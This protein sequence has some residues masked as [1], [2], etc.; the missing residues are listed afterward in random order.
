MTTTHKLAI[1][2][3][4]CAAFVPTF[5]AAASRSREPLRTRFELIIGV[6]FEL[7]EATEGPPLATGEVLFAEDEATYHDLSKLKEKLQ[8]TYGLKAVYTTAVAIKDIVVGATMPMPTEPSELGVELTL[9]DYDDATAT[10][11]VRLSAGGE[12]LANPKIVVKLGGRAI[13]AA[14]DGERAP[15]A[16]I[17]V[18]AR[19][20]LPELKHSDGVTEPR[21]VEKVR[22]TY[23]EGARKE[24]VQ[25]TVVLNVR[26]APDGGVADLTVL[27]A[28][29]SGLT[30]AAL[31][32][33]KRWRYEPAPDNKTR[34]V[35]V[36]IT[37]RLQ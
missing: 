17:V 21:V 32:A 10:Y 33:V 26:I 9:Q 22:P 30:E 1:V 28:A 35:I 27:Q 16:F 3:V 14:R 25:G 18:E 24:K 2:L 7:P 29:G 15:Y 6:P 11:V 20:D 13:V 12:L 4:A 36:T 31:D 5:S 34:V 23:P 37:F 8:L 19:P